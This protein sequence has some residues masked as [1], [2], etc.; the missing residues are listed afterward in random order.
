M[1][2]EECNAITVVNGD[3]QT[4]EMEAREI[5][6]VDIAILLENQMEMAKTDGS[7]WGYKNAMHAKLIGLILK[8]VREKL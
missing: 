7:L 3:E 2:D 4:I 6:L 1:R 8:A 5:S